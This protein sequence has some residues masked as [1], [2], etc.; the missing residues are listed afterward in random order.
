MNF[1]AKQAAHKVLKTLVEGWIV[2]G[3]V[4]PLRP[5]RPMRV[6]G[7]AR[8]QRRSAPRFFGSWFLAKSL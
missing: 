1:R 5:E 6:R 7:T 3:L 8:L 2:Y 4:V